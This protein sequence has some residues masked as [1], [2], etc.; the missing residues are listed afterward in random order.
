MNICLPPNTLLVQELVADQTHYFRVRLRAAESMF[1]NLCDWFE[2]FHF[3]NVSAGMAA[4]SI[5]AHVHR[6]CPDSPC[7]FINCGRAVI[8]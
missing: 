6:S 4:R 1:V 5:I 3:K 2:L 7:D 8:S